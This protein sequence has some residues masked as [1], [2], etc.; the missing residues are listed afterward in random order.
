[1]MKKAISI[2]LI[3]LV[4]FA[5]VGLTVNKHYCGGTLM[6]TSVYAHSESC[7]EMTM[8]DDCCEDESIIFVVEDDFQ[9]QLSS[10][11]VSPILIGRLNLPV[12]TEELSS[13]VELAQAYYHEGSPPYESRRIYILDQS[14]LI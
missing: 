8:P 1:M 5:S 14:F 9:I 2:L 4:S 13:E 3:L 12:I 7:G 11:D 10:I 6:M